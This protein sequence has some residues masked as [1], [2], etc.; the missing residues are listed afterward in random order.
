LAAAARRLVQAALAACP[1]LEVLDGVGYIDLAAV[2]L[3]PLQCLREYP[4]GRSDEGLALDVLAVA[5]LLA[6]QH[7]LRLFVAG[8]EDRLRCV[9]PER[10]AVAV[11][12]GAA[13]GGERAARGNELRR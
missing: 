12:G 1:P 4:P 3:G 5:R 2:D 6:D 11:V 10:A 8:A 7:Q 13:K 9:L